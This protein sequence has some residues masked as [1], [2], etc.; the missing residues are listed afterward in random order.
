[1]TYLDDAQMETHFLY[2][3]V[4][5]FFIAPSEMLQ[6]CGICLNPVFST[7]WILNWVSLFLPMVATPRKIIV[8]S[9]SC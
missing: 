9:E 7:V 8:N 2:S 1:M 5:Q 6:I 4:I 3:Q